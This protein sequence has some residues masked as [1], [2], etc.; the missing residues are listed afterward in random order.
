MLT[1]PGSSEPAGRRVHQR[2]AAAESHPPADHRACGA[3]RAAVCHQPHA[4]G[5]TRLCQQDTAEVP[6]TYAI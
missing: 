1:R 4:Q 2:A 3:G 6:G 5:L